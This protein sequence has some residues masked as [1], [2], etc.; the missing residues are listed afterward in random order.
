VETDEPLGLQEYRLLHLVMSGRSEM[1]AAA[2]LGW[3]VE[4]VRERL[5]RPGVRA[6]RHGIEQGVIAGLVQRGEFEPVGLARV[7]ARGAMGRI[8]QQSMTERDG[9][10]R[11]L[12]NEVVLKYAGIEPPR[13]LEITTPDRVLEQMSAAELEALAER[14]VWPARFK[15]VLRAFLPAPGPG[16]DGAA[17]D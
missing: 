4:A 17:G 13:R 1:A 15:E 16:R 3:T 5:A 9:R 11:L 7:A 6:A 10:V 12:A 8:V 2:V 14:R